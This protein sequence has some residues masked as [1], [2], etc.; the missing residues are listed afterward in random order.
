M[1]TLRF[2]GIS[3]CPRSQWMTGLSDSQHLL[4]YTLVCSALSCVT[5]HINSGVSC[6][7][8][9]FLL[10][11]RRRHTE[12]RWVLTVSEPRIQFLYALLHPYGRWMS[13]KLSISAPWG[14]IILCSFWS[15]AGSF[16]CLL[17]LRY[18]VG[19]LIFTHH[20]IMNN[21][22]CFQLFWNSLEVVGLL[23]SLDRC[24]KLTNK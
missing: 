24:F 14:K 11:L 4:L 22:I 13:E 9:P 2:G 23:F 8:T 12:M 15:S 3:K 10:F 20:L 19:V 7:T 16:P 5:F 6:D 17:C 21:F 18:V 1:R